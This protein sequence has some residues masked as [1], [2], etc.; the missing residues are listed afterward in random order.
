[1]R[2]D[3]TRW[4]RAACAAGVMLL[5]SL[6][7]PFVHAQSDHDHQTAEAAKAD[8]AQKKNGNALV[9][10]V[11]QATARF[12]DVEVAKAEGYELQF[13]CVS[14]SESGAMGMHFGCDTP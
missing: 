12:F 6:S 4:A 10:T 5:A 2:I 8:A 14:G 1:M 13:G 11:R 7:T 9:A 3:S